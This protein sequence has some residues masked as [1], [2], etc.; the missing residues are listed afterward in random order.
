[1][2][3]F[4]SSTNVTVTSPGRCPSADAVTIETDT[5]TG[6]V[7]VSSSLPIVLVMAVSVHS[8]GPIHFVQVSEIRP[9][10]F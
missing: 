3:F 9:T 2:A 10:S 4:P 8:E 1:M 5:R 7:A 6:T